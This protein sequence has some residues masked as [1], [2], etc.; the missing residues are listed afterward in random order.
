MPKKT[1][2]LIVGPTAVGKTALCVNIAKRFNAEIFSCDSRQFYKEMAIGTAKPSFEEM[3]GVTHHFIDNLSIHEQY[4]AGQF[5]KDALSA[6]EKYFE[7]N[8]LAIMTGGSGLFAKAITHG[9]DNFPIVPDSIR[10]DLNRDLN[11]KGIEFLQKELKEKDP[12]YFSKIDQSNPQRMVRALEIIRFTKNSY[13]Q[14]LNRTKEVN[15][16]FKI[17]KI[18]LELPRKELYE[19]INE[20]VDRMITLGLQAEVEALKLFSDYT[21]LNTVGY[22]EFFAFLNDQRELTETI[23]LIKRNTRRFAKR[24]LTWFK[25][26]DK[27]YWFSSKDEDGVIKLI[28]R[29]IE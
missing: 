2:I 16:P 28:E 1:L 11:E 10:A 19:R 7:T 5:E 8:D 9:F 24:Q 29:E 15:R 4:S 22:K 26:Q 14:Y 23:E 6:L 20:R 13:S 12:L 3:N 18:G 17:I 27:F 25:N 21:V